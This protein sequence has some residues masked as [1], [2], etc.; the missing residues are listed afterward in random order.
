MGNFLFNLLKVIFGIILFPILY[1]CMLSFKPQ[2]GQYPS[3][4][5]DFFFYGSTAFLFSYLFVYRFESFYSFGQNLVSK[6]FQFASPVNDFLANIIPFYA[7]IILGLHALITSFIKIG[8]FDHY[9]LFFAGFTL[10]MHLLL[11]AHEMHEDDNVPFKPSYFFTIV[12][13]SILFLFVVVL[14]LDGF[15]RD[16]NFPKYLSNVIDKAGKL[17]M[18]GIR[19]LARKF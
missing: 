5:V 4:H 10:T 3:N 15:A 1:A 17:Y 19:M 2:M 16:F 13:V 14:M 7:L 8:L 18:D 9:F 6:I 12:V 11:T